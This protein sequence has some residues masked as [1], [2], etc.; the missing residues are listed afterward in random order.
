VWNYIRGRACASKRELQLFGDATQCSHMLV[1]GCV[2]QRMDC[3]VRCCRMTCDV[4][5]CVGGCERQRGKVWWLRH[6]VATLD[7]RERTATSNAD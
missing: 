5:T 6:G 4:H 1:C 2:R 7:V 3:V